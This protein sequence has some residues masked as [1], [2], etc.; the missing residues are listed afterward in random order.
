MSQSEKPQPVD[1]AS[2]REDRR[3]FLRMLSGGMALA[4]V[5]MLGVGC[6]TSPTG[7]DGSSTSSSSS[8]RNGGGGSSSSNG[9]GGSSSSNGGGGSSS[10]F[11]FTRSTRS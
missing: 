10:G 8:S 7:P 9:G 6:G 1:E 5:G 11:A 2:R 3:Q 4:G